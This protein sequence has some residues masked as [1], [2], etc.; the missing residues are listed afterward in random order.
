M[1]KLKTL[2]IKKPKKMNKKATSLSLVQLSKEM[3]SWNAEAWS[4]PGKSV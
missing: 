1:N 4:W 2:Q 3:F